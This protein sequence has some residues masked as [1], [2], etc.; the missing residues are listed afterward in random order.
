MIAGGGPDVEDGAATARHHLLHGP[1]GQV[2]DGLDVDAH[3]RDLVGD[4]G[5]RDRADGADARVVH[6]DVDGQPAIGGSVEKARAGVGIGD[7]AG[8]H[9]DAYGLAEFGG[10][11]AQPVLPAGDERDAVAAGGQFSR[12][13]GADTG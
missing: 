12:D 6:Q 2:D 3:L 10:E 5:L 8:D 7:V 1:G 9:L 4:R 13:V 11:V